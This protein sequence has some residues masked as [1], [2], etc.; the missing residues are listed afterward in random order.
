MKA[1]SIGKE[2]W[3]QPGARVTEVTQYGFRLPNGDEVWGDLT[4]ESQQ[5]SIV[6]GATAYTYPAHP[7]AVTDGLE[8][9]R[10]QVKAFVR[11]G[12]LP[13][14]EVEPHLERIVRIERNVMVAIAAT[15]DTREF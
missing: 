10:E 1:M 13:A 4:G 5:L 6:L 12:L 11:G 8:L 3:R 15:T 14:D 7:E 9:L 2:T